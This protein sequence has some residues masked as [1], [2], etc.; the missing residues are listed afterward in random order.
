MSTRTRDFGFDE[1]SL[2]AIKYQ[3]RSHLFQELIMAADR[4]K[5]LQHTGAL[6]KTTIANVGI[7]KIIAKHT[8]IMLTETLG[9]SHEE[10]MNAHVEFVVLDP[11]S[12]FLNVWKHVGIQEEEFK[13][14]RIREAALRTLAKDLR[15]SINRQRSRVSGVFTK[16]P[17]VM[18]VGEKLIATCTS[19]QVAAIMLHELGHLF[20]S[21][22]YLVSTTAANVLISHAA[23]SLSKAESEEERLEIVYEVNNTLGRI[24]ED[25]AA[26]AAKRKSKDAYGIL[27]FREWMANPTKQD[28][29]YAFRNNE[30]LADQFSSMHGAG[31]ALAMGLDMVY[32]YYGE[33]MRP[34]R[35]IRV[36]T[37]IMEIITTINMVFNPVGLLIL[38]IVMLN[39][40]GNVEIYD[41][42]KERV[43]RIRLNL[44]QALKD[45]T[46]SAQERKSLL[47]DLAMLEMFTDDMWEHT[48]VIEILWRSLTSERRRQYNQL[49]FQQELEKIANNELF[50]HS[51]KLKTIAGA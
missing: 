15:G 13:D 25:P 26:L 36:A 42:P 44:V 20:I 23:A 14:Y 3:G 43:E 48:P 22:E 31:V 30:Y 10:T 27:L 1:L 33:D 8:G 40:Y 11:N 32:R 9:T 38:L 45:R 17:C 37:I 7:A 39:P 46:L 4:L 29:V 12:P 2:E 24:I 6:N 28:G 49:R 18:S 19:E 5:E 35:L 21:F 41:K 50:V 47:A 51:S 16:V 34:G